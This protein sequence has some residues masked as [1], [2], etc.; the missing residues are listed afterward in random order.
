MKKMLT[1]LCLALMNGMALNAQIKI[2][3]FAGSTRAD[4]YNKKLVNEAAAIAREMGAQVTVIDLKD[5]PMPLYDADYEAKQGMPESVKRLRAL[6]IQSDALII[7]S[8]EY[9]ASIP[10]LLKNTLDWVSRSEQGGS[11][12]GDA[13]KGKKIAIMSA[14]P[15]KRGG[16]RALVHLRTIIEDIGGTVIPEEVSIPLAQDYFS[17]KEKSENLALKEEIQIIAGSKQL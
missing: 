8:P 15:G 5:Y 3:A 14:S 16:K 7:A 13:F 11:A 2:V 17:N 1:L 9:N 6:M 10:A 12:R 4:S